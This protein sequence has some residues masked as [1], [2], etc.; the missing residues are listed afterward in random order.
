MTPHSKIAYLSSASRRRRG[1]REYPVESLKGRLRDECLNANW[2]VNFAHARL[3]IEA[4]RKEYNV[5]RRHS[6]L[7]YRT[8]EE[9]ARVFSELTSRM[10]ATL[11]EPPLDGS[12]S[13]SG[14]RARTETR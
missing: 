8:P 1:S 13:H 11:P 10:A 2:L 7:D 14:A 5:E 3:R 9:F 4:W 12:G 6:S